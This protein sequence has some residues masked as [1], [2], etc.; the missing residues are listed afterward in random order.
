MVSV[1]E[2][3]KAILE[4]EAK[5]TTY[6]N[7]ER[8][9]WLYIVRD[10]LTAHKT[11]QKAAV[12]AIGESEFLRAVS[13]KDPAKAWLVVDELVSATKVLCPKMYEAFIE[14]LNNI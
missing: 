8:L 13:G 3:D 9:A 7:C 11:E 12:S 5:D 14:K 2:L 10:H 4:H 1:D 6:A